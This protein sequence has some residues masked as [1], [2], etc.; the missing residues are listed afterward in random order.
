MKGAKNS[1]WK[2]SSSFDKDLDVGSCD[3]PTN[4][5]CEGREWERPCNIQVFEGGK[6]KFTE[7]VGVRISG[8]WTTAFPQKS[9]TFYARRDYGSN[10]MQY[11]FFEGAAADADGAKIKEYKKVTL[12]NGGNDFDH[13]RIRD[14]L[15]QSLAAG[16]HMGTQAKYDY[17]VFLDGEFWGYYCM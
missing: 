17:I 11:D 1:E 5:N 2:N 3:N 16:L 6:L 12:R 4:Y 8:N 13:A 7:D 14:D 9:L 10:K 15:N